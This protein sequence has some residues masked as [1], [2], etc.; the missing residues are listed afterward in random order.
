MTTV[1]GQAPQVPGTPP[2]TGS[3]PSENNAIEQRVAR[4]SRTALSHSQAKSRTAAEPWRR[5]PALIAHRGEEKGSLPYG[6]G[7]GTRSGDCGFGFAH[8]GRSTPK[9]ARTARE[10]AIVQES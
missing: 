7:R 3:A 1:L 2:F 10:T 6:G 9:D 4:S 8:R 5:F